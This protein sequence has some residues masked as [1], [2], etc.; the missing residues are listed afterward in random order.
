MDLSKK[1]A[2]VARTL[3]IGI[4]R[5]MFNVSRIDEIKKAITKQDV[6]DLVANKSIFIREI[7]GRKV[8]TVRKRRR[9]G[10][11]R[12]RPNSRKRDYIILTRKLRA[13]I[14][15]IRKH[16]SINNEEFTK[17]RKGIRSK[18]FKNRAHLKEHIQV[19]HKGV[20]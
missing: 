7:K 15:E 17:I 9:A 6:R 11:I 16:G 4:G 20:K 3:E 2:L 13:Y 1:R 12:M 10:S 18:I 5:V 19:M 8:N 14:S